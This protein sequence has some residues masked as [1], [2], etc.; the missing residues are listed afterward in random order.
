MRKNKRPLLYLSVMSLAV[1]LLFYFENPLKPDQGDILNR[2]LLETF[3]VSQVARIEIEHLLE[4]VQLEKQKGDWKVASLT[5][6]IQ[7]N[8]ESSEK[9]ASLS[10][11]EFTWESAD[12]NMISLQLEL[13]KELE[14]LSQ[15]GHNKS[16]HGRYHVNAGGMKIR[17]FD[18]NNKKLAN[19]IVG[20][21]GP[22]FTNGYLRR[23]EE[24]AVYLVNRHLPTSWPAN[25]A[26]WMAEEIVSKTTEPT[27]KK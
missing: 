20:K 7:K 1:G 26:A 9:V 14:I 6:E 8:L 2:P 12:S 23:E 27:S 3:T 24:E 25:P 11:A 15:V 22:D 10:K 4:G 17:L 21:I 13:L 18:K 5:S 16:L 19:L